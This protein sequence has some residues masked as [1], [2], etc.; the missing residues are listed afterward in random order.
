MARA[1][2]TQYHCVF[3]LGRML[4]RIALGRERLR[5]LNRKHF[6]TRQTLCLYLFKSAAIL[7]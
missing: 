7:K 3:L 2:S 5:E 4:M 1:A 6:S